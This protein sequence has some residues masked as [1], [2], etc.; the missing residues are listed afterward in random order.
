MLEVQSQAATRSGS[1]ECP[2]TD[3]H[4]AIFSSILT[5]QKERKNLLYLS[6]YK[7]TSLIMGSPS[8]W[9]N[10]FP[11]TS[12]AGAIPL[13]FRYTTYEFFGVYK[14]VVYNNNSVFYL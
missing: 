14:P 8:L 2:L 9:P 5:S 10:Y 6:F 3:L 1:G 12:P 7:D 13:E 4:T 11:K